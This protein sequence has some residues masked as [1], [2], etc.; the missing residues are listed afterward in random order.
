MIS[1]VH[2]PRDGAAEG[3][4][5]VLAVFS[6]RYDAHLVPDLLENLAP[7]T[8]G[9]VAFD[10]RRGDGVFSDEVA[11]R[12]ALLAAAREAGADWAL[13]VDP[14]ERF[15]ASLA[16]EMPRLTAL[17]APIAWVF[18]LRELYSPAA[19]RVDGVWGE[20]RQARL[21]WLGGGLA[22]PFPSRLHSSWHWFVP[23]VEL[24]DA[25]CNLY[26]LKMIE[27][28]RRRARV[29]LYNALDPGRRHQQ[30]GYDYLADET[31]LRL[32]TIP[33]GRGYRPAHVDDGGL[34]M[35]ESLAGE[36][37]DGA[38]PT[39]GGGERLR[40]LVLTNQ[41]ANCCG[42]EVVALEVAHWF[43]ER[44]DEVTLAANLLGAPILGALPAGV[45]STDDPEALRLEA[46][47]LV[48][49]QHDLLT[50]LPLDAF[51][52]AATAG[53]LPLVVYVSLSPFEPHEALDPRLPRALS[54]EIF[55]NSAETCRALVA[56][57]QGTIEP[58][59][60]RLFHNA[61]PRPYWAAGEALARNGDERLATI[62]LVSHHFPP[63]LLEAAERLR[64]EG[65]VAR[66]FGIDHEHRLL[67]PA[68]L[69]AFDAVVTI[70]KTVVYALATGTPVYLY[71]HFGGDGW[72]TRERFERDAA[73][74]FSGRP[75]CRR[76]PAVE[77]VREILDGFPRAAHEM[78]AIRAGDGLD[79]FRLDRHLEPLR[80][81]AFDR[82]SDADAVEGLAASLAD[83]T[84]RAHFEAARAKHRVMR[85]AYRAS[86]AR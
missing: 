72:L 35:S 28:R 73:H 1:V 85:R 24:R 4:P 62:A 75:D 45:T 2:R 65:V 48:W 71:D 84:F 58:S 37:G 83:R 59:S 79:R 41:F 32:E 80:R 40:V 7:A 64:A 19:Y 31:G 78:R 55:A 30:I 13:A 3:A 50:L 21:L 23:S 77:I 67:R 10:D 44:G 22:E 33:V 53:R 49:C 34:W 14:D 46:F 63:E 38:G 54:A 82:A 76:R 68:D 39:A 15:E 74:N 8:D 56:R 5:R 57:G 42:S 12:F 16:A 26:H 20:K 29:R 66:C 6:Y 18:P 11:R 47:D 60:I 17:A 43:A 36:G 81:R 27:P 70:G 61:A 9:W 86:R 52:R 69:A 25:P 51:E